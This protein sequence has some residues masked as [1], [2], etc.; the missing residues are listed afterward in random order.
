MMT[1]AEYQEIDK[2]L[3]KMLKECRE[4]RRILKKMMAEAKE[5]DNDG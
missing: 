5:K 1:R 4:N 3:A 2:Q